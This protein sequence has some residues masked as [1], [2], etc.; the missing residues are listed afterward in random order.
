MAQYRGTIQGNR[1]QASRLGH[2]TT[3]LNVACNGW[4]A[5]VSVD[6]R[7][8][9]KKDQDVFLIYATGG[10][11]HGFG[12]SMIAEFTSKHEIRHHL[13]GGRLIIVKDGVI[14]S[15]KTA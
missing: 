6:A 12:A 15:D 3:G 5:G 11:G 1:S 10:S 13:P 8:L 7:Y 2:K 14:T 4:S 9:D